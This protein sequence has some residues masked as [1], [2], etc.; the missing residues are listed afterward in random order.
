MSSEA[1]KAAATGQIQ[2]TE[3][4]VVGFSRFMDKFKPQMALAL[5]KHLNADRMTR[6]A[7]T[8]FSKN[9]KLQKCDANTIAGSIMTACTLGLEIGVQGQGYLVP[10]GTTCTFVPGWQGLVDLVSRSGRGT[11]WTGAVFEGDD[12]EYALG[13][14]PFVKHKPG[15]EDD[16]AKMT[17]VYSIGRAKGSDYPIIEV[18]T[19]SKI[20]KHLAKYNKV[21]GAHYALKDKGKDFEMYARKIPLL[22]VLKYMPKSI[23]VA[24]AIEQTHAAEQGMYTTID[25]DFTVTADPANENPEPVRP[26]ADENEAKPQTKPAQEATIKSQ[27]MRIH[28]QL[29]AASDVDKL[30]EVA[31][32]IKEVENQED[33]NQLSDL[34]KARYEWFTSPPETE[35]PSAPAKRTR[36]NTAAPE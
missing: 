9:P 15:D 34:Y 13:D 3:N 17:H 1:L 33:R 12:F 16:I 27:E 22:Q 2:K 7:M 31:D 4:P 6:L 29:L 32:L 8:E 23:E 5:P 19:V 26:D 10:Y 35:N 11:V 14:N 20:Y 36:R 18:W 30:A 28:E 25:G 21:G 24:A